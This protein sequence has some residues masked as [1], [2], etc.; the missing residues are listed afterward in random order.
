MP[1]DVFFIFLNKPYSGL[2]T[3]WEFWKT[4]KTLDKRLEIVSR[5]TCRA[6]ALTFTAPKQVWM[7]F[8]L[9]QSAVTQ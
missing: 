3:Y 8:P 4:D 6:F 7:P 5:F 9:F 2:H 1:F